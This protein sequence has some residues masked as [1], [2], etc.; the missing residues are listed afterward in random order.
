[1]SPPPRDSRSLTREEFAETIADLKSDLREDLRGIT[2][3][4]ADL[5][6]RTRK[7]EIADAEVRVQIGYL[8]AQLAAHHDRA[9]A[10]LTAAA[11]VLHPVPPSAGAAPAE[12]T[13]HV[14]SAKAQAALVGSSIVLLT[15]LFKAIAALSGVIGSKVLDVWLRK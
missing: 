15:V 8:Q 12:P 6:G 5:N 1:M 4:L 2:E 11:L 14:L 13:V 10:V 3:H 7:G 9:A